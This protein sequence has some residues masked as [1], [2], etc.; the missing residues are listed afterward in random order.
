EHPRFEG[1][2]FLLKE[3]NQ[4]HLRLLDLLNLFRELDSVILMRR[5]P[6][7]VEMGWLESMDD[8]GGSS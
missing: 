7:W 1:M 2:V 8:T 4:P 3:L 5:I 6:E